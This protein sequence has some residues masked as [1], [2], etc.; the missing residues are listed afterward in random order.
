M[1]NSISCWSSFGG[2]GAEP[3]SVPMDVRLYRSPSDDRS[4]ASTFRVVAKPVVRLTDVTPSNERKDALRLALPVIEM[5]TKVATAAFDP[6]LI[7]PISS[8]VRTQSSEWALR[9]ADLGLSEAS[10]VDLVVMP[11]VHPTTA[12]GIQFEWHRKGFD[13]EIEVLPS[14][15]ARAYVEAPE[16]E[17]IEADLSQGWQPVED[18][19]RAVLV[20]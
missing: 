7:A 12:G 11:S 8:L 2:L 6:N 10:Q 20:K 13:L 17:P 14:G 1:N 16:A 18:A 3:A 15:Q 19:L 5:V 4:D 9:L